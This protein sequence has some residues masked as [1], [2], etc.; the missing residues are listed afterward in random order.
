MN[1]V[2]V[3]NCCKVRD[4]NG[5]MVYYIWA[6]SGGI[7]IREEEVGVKSGENE[8]FIVLGK[9]FDLMNEV[10]KKEWVLNDLSFKVRSNRSLRSKMSGNHYAQL[11]AKLG[12]NKVV[13]NSSFSRIA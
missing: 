5:K 2:V 4:Y 11:L 9:L 6:I 1:E 7:K 12:E 13:Y 3:G 10:S 8:V